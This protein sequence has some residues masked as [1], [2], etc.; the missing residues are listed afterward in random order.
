MK[1]DLH[2]GKT[3]QYFTA[4]LDAQNICPNPKKRAV[5]LKFK[6]LDHNH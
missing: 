3:I 2:S 5:N 1:H 6:N 4:K